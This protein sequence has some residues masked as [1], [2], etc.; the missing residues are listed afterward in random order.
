VQTVSQKVEP[1]LHFA[2]ER[3]FIHWLHIAVHMSA[4][5]TAILAFAPQSSMG[6]LYAMLMLPLSLVF[7]GYALFVFHARDS[8]VPR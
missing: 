2:N 8:K 3:T 5:A 4:L 6:E 7:I 1:K